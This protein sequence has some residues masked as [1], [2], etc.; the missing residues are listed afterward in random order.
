[1]TG[2]PSHTEKSHTK[3]SHQV[4]SH[5]AESF[6]QG[7]DKTHSD[8]LRLSG[9]LL[10]GGRS[11]R[12]GQDKCFIQLPHTAKL[13]VEHAVDLMLK[14]C[15][16]LV[17]VTNELER[18][19]QLNFGSSVRLCSDLIAHE[20]PLGALASAAPLLSGEW[21]LVR[22]VD[23]PYLSDAFI[24]LMNASTR[25]QIGTQGYP[26]LVLPLTEFGAEPLSAYYK[27]GSLKRCAPLVFKQGRRRV[28]SLCEHMT[29]LEL[30]CE[31]LKEID[32]QLKNFDNINYEY[33]LE[34]LRLLDEA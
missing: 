1:M 29:T 11:S 15:F 31:E 13:M 10:A 6:Q 30:K 32:P 21:C 27:V 12:M 24:E 8:E 25:R 2:A 33:Q 20:G 16:E 23:M 18:M 17:I 7:L 4:R 22:A 19:K 26:D 9:I 28:L 5:K 3:C 34:K 14:Y